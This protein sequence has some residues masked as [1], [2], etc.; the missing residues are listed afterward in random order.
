MSANNMDHAIREIMSCMLLNTKCTLLGKLHELGNIPLPL[1][2]L[3]MTISPHGSNTIVT[4]VQQGLRAP[5]LRA[6]RRN[7]YLFIYLNL[8]LL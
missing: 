4:L 7:C 1:P 5:R 2:P 6:V 3:I 8:L